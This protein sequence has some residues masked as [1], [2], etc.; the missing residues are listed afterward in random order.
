M[1][2]RSSLRTVVT[3]PEFLDFGTVAGHESAMSQ[4]AQTRIEDLRSLVLPGPLTLDCGETL[5]HVQIAYESWG[6]PN[7]D[8][9][10]VILICHALTGDQFAGAPNPVTGRP[11]WWSRMIGPGR[12]IDTDRYHVIATNVLGGCMGTTGPASAG[13]D[14][15]PWGTRFPVITI[16]DMVRAQ[17]AFI[18]A[19]G[20]DSL[21]CV[22]GGSM[23]GM[24]ALE[25]AAQAP[26]QVFTSVPIATSASHS[27][28]N[29]A[30]YEVGRQAITADPDWCEGH[31]LSKGKRPGRGLAIARMAAHI[32]YVS[33]SALKRKFDRGLQDREKASFSFDAD[34]QV[35]SYLRYQGHSFVDRFDANS[36]LYVTRAMDYFDLAARRDGRLADVFRDTPVRFCLFS[37]SSDWHY[38]PE[39]NRDITRALAAAGAEVSYLDIESDKGHD[40]FLLEE[41]VYEKALSGFL[42]ASAELRGI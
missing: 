37:F 21:F 23:G 7:A 30:F 17:R 14:G 39:A 24:Q 42:S 2:L 28:Q 9:S 20:I 36:Y 27:A 13:P 5:E 10:N 4:Q 11:A 34:F 22:I 29:I 18:A 19:K 25:W 1:Y 16:G 38:P 3:D 8:N 6:T 32:T 35:E 15:K 26:D 31:Y 41:P 12:P 33:E 40:A